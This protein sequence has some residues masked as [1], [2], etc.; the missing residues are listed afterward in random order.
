MGLFPVIQSPCPYK[1]N[2]AA[3]MDGDM[4]RMCNRQVIDLM[5]MEDAERLA[6]LSACSG[7]IC[8]SYKLPLKRAM[9][10]AALAAATIP[11]AVAAQEAPVTAE[12]APADEAYMDIIVG[13]IKDLSKVTYVES[14]ADLA[15]PEL[16][17]E[18]EEPP[19][20]APKPTQR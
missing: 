3:V 11:F 4:C 19:V 6:F 20:A 10:A 1:S 17:V 12:A 2:L 15:M 16:P 9:A 5:D 14:A 18:Y 13:G 7:E 8:V